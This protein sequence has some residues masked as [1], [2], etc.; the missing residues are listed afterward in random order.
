MNIQGLNHFTIRTTLVNETADFYSKVIGMAIGPR[1][2]FLFSGV[3]MYA[4][5]KPILHIVSFIEPN[6]HMDAYLGQKKFAEGSGCVDHISLQG[7][8]LS[9]MQDHLIAIGES[10]R[11]RIIPEI[12]EHQL[13]LED[14]NGVTIELIFPFSPEDRVMGE[15]MPEMMFIS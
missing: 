4:G 15:A 5:G 8:N 7:T 1:P 13:F 2:A 11:E 9:E 12:F 6:Q 14:P 10:F 3:W